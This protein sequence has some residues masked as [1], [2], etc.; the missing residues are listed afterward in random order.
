M[1]KRD[2]EEMIQ[3]LVD[4][5][6][7]E[8]EFDRLQENL[9]NDPKSRE[10]FRK[11]MEVEMLLEEAM[12]QRVESR[13]AT[14]GMDQMLHRRR[15][16]DVTRATLAAAAILVL[17]AVIMT[18]IMI[19]PP[20]PPTLV[21]DLV[22]GTRWEV[23][24]GTQEPGSNQIEVTEGATVRV[25]SGTV[26]MELASGA[27][28]VMR[29]PAEARFPKVDEPV[30]MHGWLW[31]D[32]AGGAETF[33]V[34]TSDLIVR[35]TGTRFGIR[36]PEE[37]PAE[38]HLIEGTLEVTP[39]EGE[40][41]AI[42]LEPHDSGFLV[43]QEGEITQVP[44][45]PDPFPELAE[46]LAAPLDYRTTILS[47]GP[48]GYWQFED[49]EGKTLENEIADGIAGYRGNTALQGQP[50]VGRE[51]DFEGFSEENYAIRLM[52]DPL[53]SVITK[54]DVPGSV[55]REEG[56]VAFWIRR[57]ADIEQEEILWL[58][59]KTPDNAAMSPKE[60]IMHTWLAASGQVEFFIENAKFDIQ[61]SSNFSIVDNH[62]HHVAATWGPSAVE[63][64]VD[65]RRVGR[66]DDFGS[67]KP[68]LMHGEYVRFGKPSG[69]LFKEGM[70]P[71]SG[72]VDEITIWDRPLGR[73]EITQQFKSA[74]A[75][76][77][78]SAKSKKKS[79]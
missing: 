18:F 7:D 52:G 11:S 16:R 59:G 35:N 41:E 49:S 14:G 64:Y 70:Q 63:L 56:G 2:L 38:I 36:V 40:G 73:V 28:M 60:S 69:E 48:A 8:E 23:T 71:F 42:A 57:A 39:I 15:K 50:G 5:A 32:S 33:T 62:W 30:L 4:G 10:F 6:L 31:I 51:G 34:K 44:L 43:P 22:A 67:L 3:R 20:D 76:P 13:L 77:K 26:R 29:G 19:K 72:W 45:A 21:C 61:L 68:S 27:L 25:L 78:G 74:Q 54:I 53:T 12:G 65:G 46:L 37:G 9:R 75:S 55:S 66:V 58:A 79:Q 1:T 17:A 24:G 47:Q